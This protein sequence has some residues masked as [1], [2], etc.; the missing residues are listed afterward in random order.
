MTRHKKLLYSLVACL[1]SAFSGNVQAQLQDITQPGDPIVGTS[2]NYPGSEGVANAIDN[3]PTKY[4]NFDKVNTGFT[5]TPAIGLSVVQG[6]T[7]TSAND[8]PERDPGTYT[9]EGSYDGVGFTAISSGTVPTYTARFE[10]KT[11]LFENSTPY[12]KYRLIFPTTQ[13]NSTCCMQISEVELL[14]AQAPSDVTQPG[15]AIVGTS[16]NYPGSEGVANAIDNQPTKYLNFDRLNTG[17]TVTPSVGGTR[18]TGITLTA[19]N[20]AVERD[21]ASYSLEGS[22][23]GTT[24]FPI[25]AGSVPAFP[26]RFSKNYIFFSNDRAFRAYRVIFPTVVGPGGNS[27]QI[28]E[29]ELLGVV[30][31]I[32]QD[33]TQP[34]DAIVGTSNNYP[35]SEG[36][37]NAIDNQPTKYLNF[38]KV[39]TGFTVTPGSGLTIVSGLTLTS[40]NDGP[41]RD[42]GTYTLEGSYDGVG[43]TSISSGTVPTYAARFEKKTILFSN[44]IPYLKYRLIFPTTQGN[45]TCCMQI[46]EVELLGVL[47]PTDVTQP[48]DPIVG[49][50]NNYPGSEGVANSIDNQPTKY[51]NFDRL[52]TGFT[53]TPGVGDTIVMGLTL[54]S[55]NDA[56]ERDPSSY[57]LEGSNDGASFTPISSGT[58]AAFPARFFKNYVFFPENSKSYKAYRLIFPTVVGPGGNSMQISE[59]ELLGVTPGAVNT[60]AVATLIRAQPSDTPVLLGASATFRVVLTGPWSVQWYRNGTRIPGANNAAYTTPVTTAADDGA[61]YQAVVQGRDGRQSSD[62]VMLSIFTPSTTESIAVS[63]VGG[64]ANGAPTAVLA[65]DITGYFP[66]A[67]WNNAETGAGTTTSVLN[68]S[69]VVHPTITVNWATAGTWGTG[70]G[71]E[72][73]MGRMLNGMVKANTTADGSTIT[74]SGVPSGN[75]SILVYS[76]QVPLEFWSMSVKAVTRDSGGNDVVQQRFI[77]PQNSDE[78]NPSPGFTL[79]TSE[80]AGAR[81]AGNM[82]RFDNLQ[83]GTD[84]VIQIRFHAIDGSANGPGVNGLQLLI[85]PAAVGAPPVITQQPV[86][87]NAILGGQVTLVVEATGPSPRYQW[88]KNGQP[89]QGA[90]DAVLNLSG[91]TAADAASYSVAISNPAGRIRSRNAVVQVLDNAQ[92][93]SGLTTY[94]K[95]DEIDPATT[96]PNSAAGGQAGELK[97]PFPSWVPGQVGNAL[98]FFGGDGDHVFVPNY[99]KPS[100]AMT[101]GGWIYSFSDQWGP[102]LNNWVPSRIAGAKGQFFLNVASVDGVA[103][104]NGGIEVGA[105]Q[106]RSSGPIDASANTW[107]HFAMSANGVT[108]SLYWDGQLVGSVDYFGPINVATFPWLAI[109]AELGDDLTIP[110]VATFAN[111]LFDDIAIWNRSLSDIE[112]QGV[113]TGGRNGQ[114]VSQVPPVLNINRSPVAVEDSATAQ[115][116]SAVVINVLANDTDPD[117]DTLVVSSVSA[118]SHGSAVVSGND[119]T[120][121]YTPAAGYT[122]SDSFRYSIGDGHGGIA[123][124]VVNVT[125][126][127][128]TPPTV[129]CSADIT[130]R[131]SGPN[132][133]AVTYIASATDAGGLASFACVPASGSTFAIGE[134]TVTCSATDAAGNSASCS[135][136]VTIL[137]NDQP[138]TAVIGTEALV[139]FAPDFENPVLI[140][141]NWWNACLV[142]DGWTSSASNGGAL[143]YL[144]FDELEPVPFDSGVVTTNCYEV[145]THTITLIVEDSNG[146]TGTDSKTIEV[147]TAPL[148][149]ELLIEKV[150]QSR[151]TRAI[152]RELVASLRVALNQSK[153]EKIRP[154]QNALDA[155]EKKVRAKVTA[156]YPEQSRVWIKWSQ[157]VSTGMEK[158]IKPPRKAKDHW[159]DKNDRK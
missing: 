144:W 27:M 93:T 150:N 153:N 90:T 126:V 30:S 26:A 131:A 116:G 147:L 44:K 40:A 50:S 79:V 137:P 1:A 8:G 121:T 41:E 12:L 3:Q 11:I 39:N 84:G 10:K 130:T 112:I 109:G 74:L 2:N 99:A 62:E 6:L 73:A 128:T 4:L 58:V 120:V 91:L 149:I 56:V 77:R 117:N 135:F 69:N 21:P 94:F 45:S 47:A 35:G 110:P 15:D 14:G 18:V 49:T 107:H 66:Q 64:G 82:L 87:A 9:L 43:F 86:S 83:P 24:F 34:G 55:A 53:V 118:P 72:D 25:A 106:V 122:G 145:G 42:P 140:S 123:S 54:T 115:A 139:D 89:I 78:Y 127:D 92:I 52:N 57:T 23:D 124:A 68:S 97:H 61:L 37:A 60:N 29:V 103:S 133:A 98:N 76:V 65:A 17:F 134:T 59:V 159:D 19:A 5:V 157:A 31:E 81:T 28:S 13:G 113:V 101:V 36:V 125:V 48:G 88:L 67:Y 75:H 154:T 96:A 70:T 138:P 7:L 63:F 156:A 155:F 102:L 46:S 152:K 33:V 95:L 108:L 148:A 143:T 16:N 136:K 104:L 141:C 105:N 114:N 119:T 20:D 151:V 85:N 100:A 142:L 80:T 71:N 111:G 32:A 38:D 22:L 146:L 129:A 51:L 158:C 132:G